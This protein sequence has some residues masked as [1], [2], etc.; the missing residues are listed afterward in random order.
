MLLNISGT[1]NNGHTLGVLQP[2]F[3]SS[4][5]PVKQVNRQVETQ[6]DDLRLLKSNTMYLMK[7]LNWNHD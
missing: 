4:C 1:P 5:Q 2:G 7:A 6:I 3:C